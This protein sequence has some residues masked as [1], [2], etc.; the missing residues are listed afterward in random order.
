MKNANQKLINQAIKGLI[1]RL[2]K[3]EKFVLAQAP[4]IC[5]QMIK[6]FVLTQVCNLIQCLLGATVGLGAGILGI[7]KI[8]TYTKMCTDYHCT[9]LSDG[10]Y[11]LAIIGIVIGAVILVLSIEDIA[12]LFFIKR[13][14]K[15]FLLREFR[16][17][18]K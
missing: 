3:T 11:G 9:E 2:E 17:L 13:C 6:E 4:D 7:Y 16:R 12:N 5:K 1:A 10:W 8:A 18:I 14:P 15:L